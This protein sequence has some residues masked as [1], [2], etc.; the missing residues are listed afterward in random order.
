MS[1]YDRYVLPRLVHLACGLKSIMRQRE[2]VVPLARGR[3]LEIGIGSGRNLPF[4]DPAVV[5]ELLGLDPSPEMIALARKAARAVPLGIELLIA[6]ADAIPL[7]DESVDTVLVTYALCTIADL[8][9]ALREMG[10]VLRPGGKLVFCEHGAA[11]DAGVRRWQD[12]VTP[13]WKR[14]AGGCHL[15]RDIPGL[16]QQGGFAIESMDTMYLP[17]WRPATFNY[18]GV[19][20]RPARL[21]RSD[22]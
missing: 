12:A 18:W 10:R 17:G 19:A 22:T 4:Y 15:N 5:S 7:A 1:L 13:V 16:L 11:P 8:A 14:V 2:K 3:V 21:G 6:P 9:P 20:A